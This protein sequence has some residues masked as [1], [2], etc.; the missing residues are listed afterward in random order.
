MRVAQRRRQNLSSLDDV[1]FFQSR[2]RVRGHGQNIQSLRES[3]PRT[4]KQALGQAAVPPSA[5]R[6]REFRRE[7]AFDGRQRCVRRE[8]EVVS[9][10]NFQEDR[11]QL[12]GLRAD[13]VNA[14]PPM[15]RVAS[16]MTMKTPSRRRDVNLKFGNVRKTR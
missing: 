11:R 7:D 14:S 16:L 12:G 1:S 8:L 4:A 2:S 3:V 13:G 5:Q 10:Y 9:L 15:C 6:R